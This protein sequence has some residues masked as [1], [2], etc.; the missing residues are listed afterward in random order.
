MHENGMFLTLELENHL[1]GLFVFQPSKSPPSE[2]KHTITLCMVM[3]F[4]FDSCRALA[5]DIYKSILLSEET[6]IDMILVSFLTLL[7]NYRLVIPWSLFIEIRKR[8]I[9]PI[10]TPFCSSYPFFHLCIYVT[11]IYFRKSSNQVAIIIPPSLMDISDPV[12]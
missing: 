3:G 4:H 2:S 10:E 12:L 1:Q 6:L 5:I 11:A 8:K 9:K 7:R